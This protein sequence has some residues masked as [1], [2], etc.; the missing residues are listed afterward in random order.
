MNLLR[1]PPQPEPHLVQQDR[2]TA[3]DDVGQVDDK[4]R[5]SSSDLD[6][7][8]TDKKVQESELA[9]LL[10]DMSEFESS[11]DEDPDRVDFIGTMHPARHNLQNEDENPAG[12]IAVL[13]LACWL[14]RVPVMYID[15]IR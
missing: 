5:S 14:I 6:E 8:D 7:E 11:D 13:I 3:Q 4:G 1:R 15:F 10:N 9:S 2:I 12:N